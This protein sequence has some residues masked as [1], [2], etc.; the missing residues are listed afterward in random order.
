[1][2]EI[3]QKYLKEGGMSDKQIGKFKSTRRRT[4]MNK[5]RHISITNPFLKTSDYESN[6]HKG[7]A[8]AF[9]DVETFGT[10]DREELFEH[11]M[12]KEKERCPTNYLNDFDSKSPEEA[13]FKQMWA[14]CGGEAEN[15]EWLMKV[16][17]HM[18]KNHDKQMKILQGSIRKTA[19]FLAGCSQSEG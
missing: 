7:F 12:K 13:T 4:T 5:L 1:M 6:L 17:L 19:A 16:L 18:K 11:V 3:R 15:R 2:N 14:N 8:Y 10:L 9:V